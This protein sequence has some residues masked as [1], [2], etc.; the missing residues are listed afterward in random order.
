[1]SLGCI[2]ILL[3]STN[4]K[5]TMILNYQ[6]YGQSKFGSVRKKLYPTILKC[7]CFYLNT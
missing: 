2:F 5:W 4:L 7:L 3:P 1:M 6:F